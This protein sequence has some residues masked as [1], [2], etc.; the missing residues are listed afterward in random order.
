MVGL[1]EGSIL[2]VQEGAVTLKGAYTARIFR[3]YEEPVEATAGSNLCP[4]LWEAS[5]VGARS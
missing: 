5:S 2:R 4:V 3:R 1:R